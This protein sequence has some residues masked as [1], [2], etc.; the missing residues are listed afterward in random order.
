MSDW[1]QEAVGHATIEMQVMA[2]TGD[3]H[4][5]FDQCKNVPHLNPNESSSQ[6]GHRDSVDNFQGDNL[7]CM[8][9]Q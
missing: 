8:W 6:V 1:G 7:M 5:R 9:D 3:G 4:W 2:A